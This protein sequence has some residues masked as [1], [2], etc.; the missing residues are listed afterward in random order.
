M[1]FLVIISC[2]PIR[3]VPVVIVLNPSLSESHTV[4]VCLESMP[5][6]VCNTTE[7]SLLW[8]TNST[9]ANCVYDENLNRQSPKILGVFTLYRDRVAVNMATNVCLQQ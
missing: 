2:T 5:V 6:F 4:L 3:T 7:G 8:D 9:S 1:I